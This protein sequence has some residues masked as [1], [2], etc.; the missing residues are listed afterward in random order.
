MSHGIGKYI[1]KYQRWANGSKTQLS[2]GKQ[3]ALGSS[4]GRAAIFSST[5]TFGGSV[6]IQCGFLARATS[7]KRCMSCCSSV[8]PSRF[9][10][11]SGEN[12]KGRPMA[13]K[14]SCLTVSKRPW[15]RV[16]DGPRFFHPM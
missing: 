8:V 10:E 1:G 9:G 4:P 16:P 5:V 6:W 2:H 7:I 14:L 12:I 15:V 11:E 3:E 13:E